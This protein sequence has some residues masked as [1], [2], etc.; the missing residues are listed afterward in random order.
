[1]AK[2]NLVILESPHKAKTVAGFLGPGY[3]VTASGGHL[4][5]LPKS[6]L[7]V[8]ISNGFE[9]EFQPVAGREHA[10]AELRSEAKKADLVYLATDPDR[11]GEAI[12][13]H[14]KEL[15]GLS[16]ERTLRVTFNEITKRVVLESM[17]SPRGIDTDLV[18]AQEARRIL[19][20]IIG[21]QL[22]PLLW[23][24][25]RR[26][27][28][29]GRVQSVTLRIV[30]DREEEIRS[31]VP[32]EYWQL[33]AVLGIKSGVS[34]TAR[35]YG[36]TKKKETL[37]SIEEVEKVCAAVKNAPWS[38]LNVK[39]TERRSNP[40]APFITASL[41]QEASRKFGM[42]T[43]RTMSI[44][45]QLYEGVDIK[46]E[47]TVGLITYMRTDSLRLSEEA[48]SDAA[49]MIKSRYG[50]DYYPGKPTRYKTDAGAQDAHEAIRPSNVS[51]IPDE[52]KHSLPSDLYKLYKLI[53]SRFLACQ[54]SPAIYDSVTVD[55]ESAGY[56]FR[57]NH[58]ALKFAGYRAVYIEGSDS[59]EEEELSPLPNM[60]PGEN[61]SLKE[62]KQEQKFTSPP[63]R[64]TEASLI[65][66]M[67]DSGIG[68]PSTYAATVSTIVDRNYVKKDGK[69]LIPTP[70]GETVT[71]AFMKEWFADIVDV[72]FTAR[73]EEDLDSIEKGD[74]DWHETLDKFYNGESGFASLIEKAADAPR[75]K[76]PVIESEEI[77]EK[78]G[79]KLV[80][81]TGRFG[82]F[83]GCPGF[84]ECDFTMPI[85]VVMPGQCPKCGERLLKRTGRS[86]KNNREYTYYCCDNRTGCGFMTFDVPVADNCPVCGQTMFKKSGRGRKTPYCINEKC[87]NFVPEEH[88]GYVKKS[89]GAEGAQDGKTSEV[90]AEA[91]ADSGA[92]V[93]RRSKTA[94][95]MGAQRSSK[96]AAG[97]GAKTAK[98][99][100]GT[101]AKA[102][103]PAV[104]TPKKTAGTAGTKKKTTKEA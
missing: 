7:G 11:E 91:S 84:P 54:M 36:T 42:N 62:L 4:R 29:A 66:V 43:R 28:S 100:A 92:D 46:G 9:P 39:R 1:M 3:K 30:T 8:D 72:G 86:K 58:S 19:D 104:K 10:I 101:R 53:W 41:L 37:H 94:A 67:K 6:K 80:V 81:R 88:R 23:R 27:L 89:S 103:K 52:I 90:K 64:F 76:L 99:S 77:C 26:G 73:M 69:Y 61:V 33:D 32:E 20:R 82:D 40:P 2:N 96:T 51:L 74:A 14:L 87:A 56:M 5:D 35:Y 65:Q 85:V 21:Y 93:K 49:S 83:L 55:S 18:N 57:A 45:Q 98:P 75:V 63:P 12:A 48:L 102:A 31:F 47:G 38:I 95:G 79:R 44:A 15:L 24:K 78:C 13:W 71:N 59:D 22:S 70:L 97:K 16:D 50:S 68:R 60:N 34:F 17:Q 25:I